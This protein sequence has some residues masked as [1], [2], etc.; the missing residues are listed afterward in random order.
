[1]SGGCRCTLMSGGCRCTLMPGALGAPL[2][3]TFCVR[4]TVARI[5]YTHVVLLRMSSLAC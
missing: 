1:M 5:M 3:E 2:A 4:E